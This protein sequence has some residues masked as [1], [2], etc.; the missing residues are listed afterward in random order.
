MTQF[1]DMFEQGQHYE[2]AVCNFRA[3]RTILGEILIHLCF[4]Q[5][6][7]D[8]K[9]AIYKYKQCL[10]YTVSTKKHRAIPRSK[11]CMCTLS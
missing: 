11:Q 6:N 9:N 10:S 8:W 2:L 3:N 1:A 5:Q 7:P 4:M